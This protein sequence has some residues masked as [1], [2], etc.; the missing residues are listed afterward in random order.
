MTPARCSRGSAL[1]VAPLTKTSRLSKRLF[2]KVSH[3]G[4]VGVKVGATPALTKPYRQT[5]LYV[6]ARDCPPLAQRALAEGV[7]TA[8]LTMAVIFAVQ[9]SWLG[10]LRPLALGVG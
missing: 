9:A 7:A 6:E 3:G 10:A 4:A 5:T 1:A 8:A 2:A